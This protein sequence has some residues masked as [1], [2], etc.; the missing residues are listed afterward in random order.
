MEI[1]SDCQNYVIKTQVLF[2]CSDGRESSPDYPIIESNIWYND[3][4]IGPALEPIPEQRSKH[5]FDLS[6]QQSPLSKLS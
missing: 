5:Y 3:N 2:I 4:P 1:N 6:T